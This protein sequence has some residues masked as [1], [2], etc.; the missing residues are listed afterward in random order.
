MADFLDTFDPFAAANAAVLKAL[1]RKRAV[2]GG[3]ADAGVSP[4]R[5]GQ[6]AAVGGQMAGGTPPGPESLA[7][8]FEGP[9]TEEERTQGLL[10]AMGAQQ[11]A[12][13]LGVL[14][15]DP[16]LSHFGQ[17]MLSRSG[18]ALGMQRAEGYQRQLD[19]QAQRMEE[20]RRAREAGQPA[21]AALT[22][23]RE[24][25]AKVAERKAAAP[26][27]GVDEK[28]VQK[29]AKEIGENPSL[30]AAKLERINATLSKTP[31]GDLEGF[32]TLG[33]FKPEQM[34]SDEAQRLRADAKELVNVLLFIQSGAGVSNQE[35][36]NKYRAY[37][38]AK[39]QTEAAFRQGIE[40][41]QND[42]ANAVKAKSAGFR[43]GV[44]EK[45]R[46]RGGV[47]EAE[48]RAAGKEKPMAPKKGH[49]LMTLPSGE[50]VEVTD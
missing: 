8:A 35:R 32:G 16:V 17:R 39:G 50:V 48:L 30:I 25:Q 12:G 13:M 28:D 21:E 40:S 33:S 14:T 6:A 5:L 11:G 29:L 46:Q 24:A 36:E 27:G 18:D 4:L 1:Q 7:G 38:I 41:L 3:A 47:G 34:L 31:K 10:R 23:L 43:P 15:G 22:R 37:G 26:T 49:E 2:E 9:P 45:Y 42:L 19:L 20:S 44:V